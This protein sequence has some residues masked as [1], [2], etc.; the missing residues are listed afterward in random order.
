VTG[1]QYHLGTRDAIYEVHAIHTKRRLQAEI[2][3]TNEAATVVEHALGYYINLRPNDSGARFNSFVKFRTDR[4]Q[5]WEQIQQKSRLPVVPR[6]RELI[7]VKKVKVV[8]L[9]ALVIHVKAR[10]ALQSPK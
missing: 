10:S 8:Y 3:P 9:L 5:W 7:H 1:S 4:L 6:F 2:L